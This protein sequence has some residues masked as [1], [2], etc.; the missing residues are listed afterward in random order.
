M[1]CVCD[2]QVLW[3]I[4]KQKRILPR[5][6]C[7]VMSCFLFHLESYT[8]FLRAAAIRP[9][10]GFLE[11]ESTKNSKGNYHLKLINVKPSIIKDSHSSFELEMLMKSLNRFIQFTELQCILIWKMHRT[12]WYNVVCPRLEAKGFDARFWYSLTRE[13]L[14]IL[15]PLQT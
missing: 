9:G 13:I 7:F 12:R 2:H 15:C 8:H 11:R 14:F 3:C 4:T 6:Y 1:C 5:R 10:S